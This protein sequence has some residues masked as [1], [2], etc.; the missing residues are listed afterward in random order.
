MRLLAAVSALALVGLS[1]GNAAQ[2]QTAFEV[3]EGEPVTLGVDDAFQR[4]LDNPADVRPNLDYVDAAIRAG[5]LEGA[6]GALERLLMI[7]PE[8]AQVRA[9]LGILYYR[10]GSEEVAR[11][12]LTKAQASGELAGARK[13]RVA[14]VLRRIG[15]FRGAATLGIRYHSN[16][17]EAPDADALMVVGSPVINTSDKTDDANVFFNGWIEHDYDLATQNRAAIVSDARVYGTRQFSVD[18]DNAF[19]VAGTSGLRFAPAPRSI[20]SLTVRPN[21]RGHVNIAEDSFYRYGVGAGVDVDYQPSAAWRVTGSYIG[22]WRDYA[23][24]KGRDTANEQ[25]GFFQEAGVA[26]RYA[27]LQDVRVAGTLRGVRQDADADWRSYWGTEGGVRLDWFI[28]DPT[29][30]TD[31][32]WRLY[33]GAELGFEDYDAP[34]P[35]VDPAGDREDRTTS[36]TLGSW[37]PVGTNW[38][39]NTS[40]T[41]EFVDSSVPNYEMDDYSALFAVTRR[42]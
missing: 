13:G 3:D 16:V 11:H 10:I 31:K 29:T 8:N 18:D 28:T 41:A 21:V 15:Q 42:F 4:L 37:M 9:D 27:P 32:R 20:E 35:R 26:V 23:P 38:L 39:L 19:M 2:A 22:E 1:W 33:A 7:E 36:L 5:N 12:H 40:G 25:D 6:I 14:T 24:M 34:N 17:N 30:L